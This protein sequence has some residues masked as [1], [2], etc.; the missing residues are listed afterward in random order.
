[1]VNGELQDVAYLDSF[2]RGGLLEVMRGLQA[3]SF[4]ILLKAI[5]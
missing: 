4:I 5:K 1:M 2:P 3:R